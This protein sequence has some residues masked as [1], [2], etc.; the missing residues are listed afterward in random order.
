MGAW[1]IV[2]LPKE[3]FRWLG[4]GTLARLRGL[5]TRAFNKAFNEVLERTFT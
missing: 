4:G 1:N 5:S 3:A 2:L